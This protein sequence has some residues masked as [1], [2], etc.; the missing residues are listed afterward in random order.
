VTAIKTFPRRAIVGATAFVLA[1]CV[2]DTAR[3]Q[4]VSYE[5]LMVPGP[6]GDK[7]EGNAGAAVTLIEYTNLTCYI[8]ES[9]YDENYPLLKSRYIDTGKVRL[10]FRELVLPQSPH[11]IFDQAGFMLA[12]CAGEGKYFAMVDAL[13]KQRDDWMVEKPKDPLLALAK[14]AGFTENSFDDCLSNQR[15]LDHFTWVEERAEKKFGLDEVPAFYIAVNET[16]IGLRVLKHNL[17]TPDEWEELFK[18]YLKR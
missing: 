8:C 10:I 2:S 1:L 5:E 3:A 9:F 15:I 6:L 12:R 13:Y 18:D 7:S 17:G 4:T 16:K 14:K 11:K